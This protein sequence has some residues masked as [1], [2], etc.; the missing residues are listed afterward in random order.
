[1]TTYE[2]IGIARNTKY[3]DLREPPRMTFYLPLAQSYRPSMN[4]LV[5]TT[6][7]PS[8]LAP[9]IQARLQTIEPALTVFNSRTLFE[10]VGRS[11]YV[12]QMQSLLLT[13]VR[14]SGT[15]ADGY[16]HLRRGGLLGGPAHS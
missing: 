15:D 6:G 5:H 7:E 8:H 13:V 4:L 11:L 3:R 12:E 14:N 2:V 1:M 10:H 16:W 9:A